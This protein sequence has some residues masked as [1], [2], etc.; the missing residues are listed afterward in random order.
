MDF[1][2]DP[3]GDGDTSDAV[4]VIN[5]SLG[6]SYGQEQ[7]DL[8]LAAEQCRQARRG[9]GDLGRQLGQPA[10]R[11][12]FAVHRRRRAQR[13]ADPDAE[14]HCDSAGGQLAGVD[15]RRVRQHADLDLGADRLRRHRRRGVLWARL[16]GWQRGAR[17]S[18]GSGADQ[19]GR[20]DRP[21]RP[22]RLLGQPEGR[23]GGRGGRHRRAHR[24]GRP[25]RRGFLLATAVATTSRPRWSSSRC[26]RTASNRA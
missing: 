21:H 23:Q 9:G 25:G 1:A 20:Q 13:R 12:R 7:D 26:C 17:Q 8:T 11:R 16:P 10:L 5:M 22:R 15:R 6:S 3:N 2:L 18:G 4:D 14:R 19:P 24:P